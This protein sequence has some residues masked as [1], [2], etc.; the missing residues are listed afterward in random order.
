LRVD[1]PARDIDATTRLVAGRHLAADHQK[2]TDLPVIGF[3]QV[4][5]LR[6]PRHP[7]MFG[8]AGQ[9][10]RPVTGFMVRET[11]LENPGGRFNV[12]PVDLAATKIGPQ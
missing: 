1:V 5:L 4:S 8:Q 11:L 9:R 2:Y 6:Q 10:A 3:E 7:A 12:G